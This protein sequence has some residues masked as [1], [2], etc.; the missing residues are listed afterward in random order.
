MYV[1]VEKGGCIGCGSCVALCPEVFFYE[2]DVASAIAT[3]I[4]EAHQPLVRKAA[5]ICPVEVIYVDEEE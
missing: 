4:G 5:A 2:D 1:T 3:P